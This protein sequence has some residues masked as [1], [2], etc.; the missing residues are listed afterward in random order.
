MSRKCFN[1]RG[2]VLLTFFAIFVHRI[3]RTRLFNDLVELRLNPK[4]LS[5]HQHF[6]RWNSETFFS[7][8][9]R[10]LSDVSNLDNFPRNG[11]QVVNETL[12]VNFF[13]TI[14]SH[15]DE[16][17]KELA[18]LG[19]REWTNHPIKIL[20][21]SSWRSGSTFFGELLN[22]FPGSYYLFEPLIQQHVIRR[23]TFASDVEI[24]YHL[25]RCNHEDIKYLK[26]S[27]AHFK[28]NIRLKPACNWT[29]N[30]KQDDLCLNSEVLSTVCGMFPMRLIKTVR[31]ET[32]KVENLMELVPDLKVISLIRDA[33]G[34][35]NS[36]DKINWCINPA[37]SN[38]E[39]VCER[40]NRDVD[41][42]F[43]LRYK[44]PKRFVIVRYEDVSLDPIQTVQ[45]ALELLN[46]PV[47]P[48]AS[49]NFHTSCMHEAPAKSNAKVV[50]DDKVQ[51]ID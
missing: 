11:T 43:K 21:L 3:L 24:L 50:A 27:R 12:I 49:K 15:V 9:K 30:S 47:V 35:M 20:V 45:D 7:F 36:R 23:V 32:Q 25:F 40:Y 6:G 13:K 26:S 5:N 46:L 19:I 1:V 39:L 16:E 28:Q 42:S 44:Y 31:F 41:S 14:F 37:C 51:G 22:Q 10:S 8:P 4:N 17:L 34:M 33:R 18:Y 2:I 48:Q 38:V 29:G